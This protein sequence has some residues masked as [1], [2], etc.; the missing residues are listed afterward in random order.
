MH[1]F[2]TDLRDGLRALRQHP[3]FA[4]VAVLTLALGLGA[5]TAIFSVVHAVLIKPLPFRAASQVVVFRN[6]RSADPGGVTSSSVPDYEDWRRQSTMF[7]GMAMLSGWTFNLQGRDV[8]ERLYG[9]RVTGEFFGVL[10][11]PPLLGRTLQPAD[12]Q[13]GTAEVVVLSYA[14]W[15]RLF[16]AD[17]GIVGQSLSMEGRP[18]IV[19]GVM[20]RGFVFPA[21]DTELWGAL[22]D[23]MAGMPRDGRVLVG[24]GR[25]KPGVALA[26]AQ[27]E[28]DTIE[29]RLAAAYPSTNR[30]WRVHLVTAQDALVG[31]AAPALLLLMTAAGLLLLIAC[32]NVSN[33]L[34]ARVSSRA[35]ETAIRLALG[36]SHG[37]IVSQLVA[38]NLVVSAIGGVAGVLLAYAAVRVCVGVGPADIPRLSEASVDGSVLA[39][40]CAATLVAGIAPAVVPAW[41]AARSDP[42]PALKD[43]NG[44]YASAS[45][46]GRAPGALIVI[47][48]ALAVTVAIAAGLLLESFA[49]L[50]SVAPGFDPHG[51]L[52]LKV[53][54]TPPRYMSTASEKTFTGK[55][56]EAIAAVPGVE[57]VASITQLPLSDPAA[58]ER[59][60]IDGR[61][62]DPDRPASAGF[63]A[64]SPAYFSTLRIPIVEGRAP[65]ET[66]VD[67][68]PFVIVINRAL[69]AR[70]FP[71]EDPIGRRIRWAAADRDHRWLTIV[72][73]AGDV[74]SAGL[75]QG[76]APAVYAPYRQRLF[77]WLRS[78]TFVVR[79]HGAPASYAASIRHALLTVDPNQPAYQ[80]APLDEVVASSIAEQRFHTE[81][82][83]LFA[84]LGLLLA[85]VGVYGTISY[86]VTGREREIGVRMALGADARR[87]RRMVVG[88]SV[89][90]TA[91]GVAIGIALAA[92]AT[93]L[94]ATLLFDVSPIDPLAFVTVPAIVIALGAG[95]AYIPARRAT[96]LDPLGVIRGR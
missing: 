78:N 39:F 3:G 88:R 35:R 40:A 56:L 13:P 83:N 8:P 51:V 25:L 85:S 42:Q 18:H 28:I 52:A 9:A 86:W 70:Y 60:E 69:A 12:D 84:L 96:R 80:I 43:G 95:A 79:T 92:A 27:S 76:E 63:R 34:L 62:P 57:A 82:L 71:G 24:V 93:R 44:G 81:L 55:A 36:A 37:R 89:S 31:S 22:K 38:E 47:E 29:A 64:V 66:D 6:S 58:T 23:E 16:G 53:F 67:T 10:D 32:A 26:A 75:D 59:F 5:N 11:T 46:R 17:P 94:M 4:A 2:L 48:V 49:A 77:S 41:R 68:A 15:T 54:L 33:L 90:L 87:V 61:A 45:G 14:L 30:G 91:V 20:P 72:G 21:A 7:A 73:V 1:T 50:T 65:H 74:K 19:I